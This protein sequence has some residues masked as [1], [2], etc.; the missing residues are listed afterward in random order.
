MGR[1]LRRIAPLTGLVFL[2]LM[3]VGFILAGNTPDSD[4]SGADVIAYYQKHENA[5][6]ASA[7]IFAFAILFGL[8]FA[9]SVRSYVRARSST[10]SAAAFGFAGYVLW[11]VGVAWFASLAFALA[12]KPEKLS[13]ETARTLNLLS[14]DVFLLFLIGM[15]A[16][17]LGNGV[18][19][20][21]SGALPKWVGWVA[22]AIG[23]LAATPVGWFAIFGVLGWTLVVCIWI[24]IREGKETSEQAPAAAAPAP[25]A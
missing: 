14:N 12:D 5:Q 16:Y 18:A 1:F 25:A 3:I 4:A 15:S 7:F 9:A 23:I 24:F 10:D 6:M 17:M 2:A 22:V 13:E 20:A 21:I 11:A 8:S 19:I